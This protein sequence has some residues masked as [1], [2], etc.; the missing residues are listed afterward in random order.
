M[1]HT[2]STLVWQKRLRKICQVEVV[3]GERGLKV[4]SPRHFFEKTGKLLGNLPTGVTFWGSNSVHHLAYHR[5]KRYAKQPLTV[6]VFDQH[7]DCCQ[8]PQGYVSCGSWLSEVAALPKVVRIILVGAQEKVSLSKLVYVPCRPAV[9]AG[10]IPTP[11]VYISIDKDA[12]KE[13]ATDW[14]SG[15]L[16]LSSLV[17]CLL[18]LKKHYHVVGADICGEY[19]PRGPWPSD[20]ELRA[21]KANEGVNLALC[22]AL[23]GVRRPCL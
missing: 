13:A 21:I 22:R 3:L 9:L 18:W 11:R 14:G 12:L 23:A 16:T 19:T 20:G 1:V 10:F 8:A 4:L 17:S 15:K 5:I 7:A 2:D 6:V